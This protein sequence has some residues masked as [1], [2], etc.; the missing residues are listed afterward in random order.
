MHPK[1]G[2]DAAKVL[3]VI[4]IRILIKRPMYLSVSVILDVYKTSKALKLFFLLIT[5]L[6]FNSIR[7]FSIKIN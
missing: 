6:V 3:Q 2:P 1:I 7:T 4:N 5:Y